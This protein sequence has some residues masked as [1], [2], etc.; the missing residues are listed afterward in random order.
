MIWIKMNYRHAH[1]R[2]GY[3][4]YASWSGPWHNKKSQIQNL[5]NSLIEEYGKD[6]NE[7]CGPLPKDR[8]YH[9]RISNPAWRIEVFQ[10]RLYVSESALVWMRL[11]GKTD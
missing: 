4:W 6:W 2:I 1:W 11:K 5:M 8:Y 7:M 3:R 9:P 10:R